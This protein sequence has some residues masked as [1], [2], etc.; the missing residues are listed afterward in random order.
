MELTELDPDR[1]VVFQVTHPTLD[2][3]AVLDPRGVGDR[4][5]ADLCRGASACMAGDGCSN[6]LAARE[7][8]NGEAAE[9]VRLKAILEATPDPVAPTT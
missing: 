8:R 2:W 5:S 6:R 7:V 1:R 3:T 4:D 9:A